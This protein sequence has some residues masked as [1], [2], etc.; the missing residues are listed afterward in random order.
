VA[1]SSKHKQSTSNR[2]LKSL[3]ASEY[4]ILLPHLEHVD[5]P[6]EKVI[7]E[8]G[9]KI[10]HVYFPNSGIVSLLAAVGSHSTLEV[11]MVGSEGVVGLALFQ[12]VKTSSTQAIVQAEGSAMRMSAAN[13]VKLSQADGKLRR[14]L[15]RFSHSLLIQISQSAVCFRFHPIEMRLARWLL[16]TNDRARTNELRMTQ[17]FLSN[18]LGVRR[19]AVNR[20]AR[21]LQSSGVIKYSRGGIFVTDRNGLE[22]ASCSCYALIRA[23]ERSI[24]S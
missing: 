3:S 19:E 7:Y 14:L 16:M 17:D 23:E 13:F 22:A 10:G 2:L 5:L 18:M 6:F 15:L 24:S 12:G 4:Q 1:T 9:D 8:L 20:A 11:G 21:S